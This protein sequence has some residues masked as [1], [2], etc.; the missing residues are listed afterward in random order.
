MSSQRI[1]FSVF[2]LVAAGCGRDGSGTAG[3][4]AAAFPPADVQTVTLEPKQ[5]PRSSDFV[6]TVRSLRS[7]TVQPQ[8][9]GFVR[10]I[11]VKAGDRV[12]A[13]AP[14]V[15]IDPDRQ[16][17]VLR[18]TESQRAARDADLTFAK[19]ELDR[20]RTLYKT[21]AVSKSQLDQAEATYKAAE[22]QLTA[23]DAEIRENQVELQY[24]RVTAP[25]S[26]IVGEIPIRL[27]D[28]VTQATTI[29]TIDQPQGLEAY[30]NVPLERAADLKPGLT[31]ELLGADGSVVASN[32]VTFIASRA[33]DA[34]QSVLVK[35]TL[36]RMPPGLR[37]MQYVR[38]RVIWSNEA[39]LTVPVL[40]VNR[41]VG[42]HFVFVAEPAEQGFVA[43]QT[44]VVLGDVIGDEYIVRSGV[45]AGQR[46]IVSNLQKIG[47]GAPVKPNEVKPS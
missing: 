44:P 11:F 3:P 28:R 20:T 2:L 32:P 13:G 19:Q 1:I 29:T 27:G 34:T 24:Y 35:T 30:I 6:A 16:Q 31:V 7:T 21:G 23:V 26:G 33:D 38:A 4:G 12:A 43:R 9:D 5:V 42:Q 14:L 37:I 47:D 41:L 36:N 46:V 25:T 22:A 45:Q 39:A 15:Q 40:A 8:V 17:A 10:R 18:T